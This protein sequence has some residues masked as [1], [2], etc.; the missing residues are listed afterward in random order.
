MLEKILLGLLAV[1]A[2]VIVGLAIYAG[3]RQHLTF[4]VP[5]PE[6][7]ASTDSAVIARGHYVVPQRGEL[8]LVPRRH[9]AR[10]PLAIAARSVPLAG[11]YH[12]DIPPGVST[13]ATSRPTRRPG[14]ASSP[15]VPSPARFAS[16]SATTAARCCRS[17]RCRGCPTKTWSR[18]CRIAC[19]GRRCTIWSRRTATT[20]LGKIVKAHRA[21]QPGRARRRR[22]RRAA[23]RSRTGALRWWSR[24][25]CAGPVTRSAARPP[26]SS[27]VRASAARPASSTRPPIP[28]IRGRR[29]TSRATPETG[30]L[31]KMTEDQFVLALPSGST[32]AEFADAL[33]ELRPH[34]ARTTCARS[35]VILKTVP[36]VKHDVGPVVVEL[37]KKT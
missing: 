21:R 16:A 34:G 17:W 32:A 26:A 28:S 19:A 29:P 10:S 7:T 25:R 37:K 24:W 5:Y 11:G 4:D 30:R 14:S 6:V 8:R 36:P 31:G 12:F 22:R 18:S 3:S 13:R 2:L 1:V 33:A 35:T 9:A 27:P 20:L 15:I 23:P